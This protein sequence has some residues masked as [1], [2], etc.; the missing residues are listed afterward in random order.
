MVKPEVWDVQNG[1][2]RGQKNNRE[3]SLFPDSLVYS[4]FSDSL[5]YSVIRF[6]DL[7]KSTSYQFDGSRWH[8]KNLSA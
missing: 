7:E 1:E 8:L 6:G 5:L 2:V 3:K 4:L